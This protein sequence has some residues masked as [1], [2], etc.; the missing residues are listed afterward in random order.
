MSEETSLSQQQPGPFR[1][2]RRTFLRGAGLGAG[3]TVLGAAA[4]AAGSNVAF[5]APAAPQEAE[6]QDGAAL[7][8]SL[9]AHVSDV[10]AGRIVLMLD[11]REVVVTDRSLAQTLARKAR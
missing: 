8:G 1:A 9:V 3:A 5:A 4:V 11:G 10:A 7:S 6:P 2:S